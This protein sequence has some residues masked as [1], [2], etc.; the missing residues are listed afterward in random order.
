MKKKIIIGLALVLIISAAV[1]AIIE[2]NSVKFEDLDKNSEYYDYVVSLAKKDIVE[3]YDETTFAPDDVCTREQ[4]ITFLH[5]AS[6]SPAPSILESFS[7]VKEDDSFA[8]AIAWA[9]EMEITR[10]YADGTFGVGKALDK[11]QAF[12]FIHEWAKETGRV[13]GDK[14][15]Y[16]TSFT[17]ASDIETYALNAFA[18]ALYEGLIDPEISDVLEPKKEITRGEVAI[19]LGKILE[20]HYHKWTPY[21][22]NGDGT[23]SRTCDCGKEKSKHTFNDGELIK[24]PTETEDGEIIYTCTACL[25]T[26]TE[27][28]KAGSEIITRA[29]LEKAIV[30]TA[31]AYYAKAEK[32]QYDSTHLSELNSNAGGNNRMTAQTPPEYATSDT[33]FYSVCSDYTSQVYYEAL[34]VVSMGEVN[35][36]LGT[37]TSYL[38][39]LADNQAEGSYNLM[40]YNDPFIKDDVDACIMRYVDFD[41]HQN[42]YS[43]R[44]LNEMAFR[45][46]DSPSFYDYTTGITFKKDGYDGEVH[47]SY[48]DDAGNKLDP[49]DVLKNNVL[50]FSENCVNTMRP[51][52]FFVNNYHALLY[53]GGNNALHC[54]GYKV[55][56]TSGQDKVE[57]GGAFLYLKDVGSYFANSAS[58][59]VVLRPLELIVKKGYDEDDGNDIVKG[60]TIP[61]STKTRI[62]YPMLEIDR[63]VQ[64]N[65]FGMVAE[66]EN[67]TYTIKLANKS[68][69]KNYTFWSNKAKKHYLNVVVTER[70]PE[71]TEYVSSSE[72]GVYENGVITWNIEEIKYSRTETLT[73]TVKVTAKAGESIV[74]D[75]GMVGN[76]PSNSITTAVGRRRLSDSEKEILVNIGSGSSTD[77][78]KY[79]IDTDFAEN[80]YKEMGIEIELPTTEEIINGLFTSEMVS[81]ISSSLY[82]T[83]SDRTM[84]VKQKDIP[85]SLRRTREMII[86]R[87]WGGRRFFIGYDEQWDFA[88]YAIKEFRTEQLQAGDIIV[89][90]RSENK[91]FTDDLSK[92]DSVSVMVYDGEKLLVAR[93]YAKHDYASYKIYSGNDVM[94][95]LSSLFTVDKDLFF[96]IRPLE[97]AE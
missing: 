87:Y 53:I 94:K 70:I 42:S 32:A 64:V 19:F 58:S 15:L 17:D 62:E 49:K 2:F 31:W 33:N 1:F 83:V 71:G 36:P 12:V 81:P 59:W 74:S 16:L 84:F 13:E 93:K 22:D 76:I 4:L 44:L 97:S 54:S 10:G 37:S 51:G 52:D 75:G 72:G 29:D 73:Y 14:D 85:D 63:T 50:E 68:N 92:L 28:A 90:V 57:E 20:K 79:G 95:Q 11:S 8:S 89:F 55:D 61:E 77:L 18:W 67:L 34:K 5:K 47:Y 21:T 48:Y 80:L 65:P 96:A 35:L 6:G 25:S 78:E 86:D 27:K 43:S 69:E 38:F 7:D 23:H 91:D 82:Q 40:K 60:I 66:G 30:Y 45:V 41:A 3:G 39:R 26:K 46:Y 88:N 56:T 9:K 24:A